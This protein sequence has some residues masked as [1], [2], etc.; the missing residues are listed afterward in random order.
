MVLV[1]IVAIAPF[2]P[3][4]FSAVYGNNSALEFNRSN[5]DE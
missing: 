2:Y 3:S 5:I 1:S 4:L